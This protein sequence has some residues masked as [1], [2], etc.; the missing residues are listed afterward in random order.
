MPDAE[1]IVQWLSGLPPLGIYATLFAASFVENVFPPSPSDFIML[2]IATLIGIG[3]IGLV[4]SIA[5]AT[6]GSTLGFMT[7]FWLGRR[8]GRTWMKS[9]K[10]PFLNK[11]ALHKVD[12]WFDKYGY[13][14]IIVNR[15]LTGTR[16]VI[17]F[18]AGMSKLSLLRTTIL[19]FISALIWNTLVIKL[20]EF[21]GSNW[22][23]GEVILSRYG[24]VLL[25]I[26]GALIIFFGVRWYLRRRKENA[27]K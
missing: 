18:F 1:S 9:G 5:V 10:V 27:G 7:A 15:F 3:T 14:V 19:C 25:I 17:S 11:D 6:A 26:F 4:P 21:L 2:F 8:F 24:T 13:W 23:Q 12:G 16:A 20:G 22:R